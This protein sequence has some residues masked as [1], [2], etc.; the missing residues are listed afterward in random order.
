MILKGE[1]RAVGKN[2]H[3]IVITIS[4][5]LWATHP[6][7]GKVPQ[8]GENWGNGNGDGDMFRTWISHNAMVESAPA[9]KA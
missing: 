6:F 8:W 5:A 3:K 2:A 9:T 1:Q 7:S 4:K